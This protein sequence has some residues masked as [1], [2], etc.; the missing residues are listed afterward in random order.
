MV[1]DIDWRGSSLKDLRDFPVDAKKRAGYELEQIQH[2]LA[3]TEWKSINHWGAGVVE[4]KLDAVAGTFRVVYVA[5][6]EEA[7]YI[8][9][10]FQKKNQQTSPKD[11]AIIKARYAEIVRERQRRENERLH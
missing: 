10:C 1:K 2:G 3:P 6:F 4:I 8:L 9:H 7:I 5:K 11:V